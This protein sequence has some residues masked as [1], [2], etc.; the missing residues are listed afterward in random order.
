MDYS[1][2]KIY[3]I[4]NDIDNDVYIGATCQ[5]LC[6]RMVNHR[7]Q[8]N[9][10]KSKKYNYKLYQKMRDLG[11]E[12]FYIE[13]IKEAPCEN[14]EQL[15]AIEG[16]YIRQYGELNTRIE[17]RTKKQY[18]QDTKEKKSAYDRIRRAE[19][20]DELKKQKREHYHN[21]IDEQRLKHKASYDKVRQNKETC[22]ICGSV[23]ISWGRKKH[24]TTK[25]HQEALEKQS[26][27]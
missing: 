10:T 15:R 17:G 22:P 20:G 26:N 4:L 23:Y 24:L 16:E 12:H 9:A 11:V 5:P 13:L 7:S 27:E 3:K 18:I 19:K 14:A 1:K 2:A 21:N 8:I 6:K 25:T